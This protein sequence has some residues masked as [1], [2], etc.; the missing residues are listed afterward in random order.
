[1]R[2]AIRDKVPVPPDFELSAK[3]AETVIMK[4]RGRE[5]IVFMSGL[6]ELSK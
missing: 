3:Q 5:R 1:M 2:D 6:L 4:R